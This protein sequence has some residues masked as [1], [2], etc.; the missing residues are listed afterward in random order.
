MSPQR[1]QRS[2]HSDD[3][4]SSHRNSRKL[5]KGALLL[6]IGLSS[7]LIA[8]AAFPAQSE[9]PD[10]KIVPPARELPEGFGDHHSG[11]ADVRCE[12]GAAYFVP[13]CGAASRMSFP[14][15]CHRPCDP[16]EAACPS[17]QVCRPVVIDPCH[18]SHCMACGAKRS[19]CLDRR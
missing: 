2:D 4:R 6:L 7:L 8:G 10:Q 12:N 19:L 15:G 18:G 14:A 3:I 1:V 16:G 13:G 11:F 5:R 9:F 17:H